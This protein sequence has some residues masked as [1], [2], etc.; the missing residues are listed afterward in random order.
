MI[1]TESN[2]RTTIETWDNGKRIKEES[3]VVKQPNGEA[4]AGSGAGA[5][6][7]RGQ[8]REVAAQT[9][10]TP[11]PRPPPPKPQPG[12]ANELDLTQLRR[13]AGATI[14]SSQFFFP[15]LEEQPRQSQPQPSTSRQPKQGDMERAVKGRRRT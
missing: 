9:S 3:R 11:R 5:G 6:A 15:Q 10:T 2:G 4:G 14:S 8:D 1:F 13:P 12:T 7:V